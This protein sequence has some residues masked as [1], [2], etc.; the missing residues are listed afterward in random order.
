M[1]VT[2]LN[3]TPLWVCSNAIRTCWQSF[4]KD[5][6]GSA[7]D[8]TLTDRVGN[9]LKQASTQEHLYYNF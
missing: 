3:H 5:D 4:D 6:N 2:L 9:K 7:I 1:E 8:L